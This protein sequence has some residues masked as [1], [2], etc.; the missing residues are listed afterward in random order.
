[1]RSAVAV[2]GEF[3]QLRALDGLAG[4]SARQ[5]CRVQETD[6]LAEGRDLLSERVQGGSGE[7]AEASDALGVAG[8]SRE[9]G[10]EVTQTVMG[11]ADEAALRSDAEEV[12]GCSQT[13]E[14]GVG[15][16]WLASWPVV[17]GPAEPGEDNVVEVNVQFGQ[18][19]IEVVFHT[20][21]P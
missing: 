5:G 11:D 17:A 13:E 9:V 1:V 12:L 14:F 7:S 15:Q 18:E 8:L 10:E 16:A 6:G 19:G 4:G 2:G 20:L 3:S 21:N